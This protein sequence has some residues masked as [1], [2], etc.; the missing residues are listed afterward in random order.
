M[1]YMEQT[2]TFARMASTSDVL[3]NGK[4]T[5]PGVKKLL[6]FKC[7]ECGKD[8]MPNKEGA[9]YHYNSDCTISLWCSKCLEKYER[10]W[11]IKDVLEIIPTGTSG[12]GVAKCIFA[13]G[14]TR[15]VPYGH[16]SN[17]GIPED[18]HE[19]LAPYRQKH[20][21]AQR[22]KEC[23]A[24]DITDTFDEQHVTC[25]FGDGAKYTLNFKAS[26]DEVRYNPKDLKKLTED[27]INRIN[28]RILDLGLGK[29]YIRK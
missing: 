27:Q 26:L 29:F 23:T 24:F 14:S 17:N 3:S 1:K 15:E 20:H 9:V 13:D 19:Q 10:H 8:F 7:Y 16:S 18:F 25:V 11:E 6:K 21:E 2:S 22:A 12:T 28:L 5:K 4:V